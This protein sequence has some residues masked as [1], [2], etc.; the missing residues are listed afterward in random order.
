MRFRNLRMLTL[1]MLLLA[2]ICVGQTVPAAADDP[3]KV[4]AKKEFDEKVVQTLDQVVSDAGFLRLPQN[5]ALIFAMVGDLY[6]K[7]DEKRARDLFRSSGS[8]ILSYNADVER[9]KRDRSEPTVEFFDP[10][11]PRKIVL[12]LVAK[13]DAELGLEMLLQTRPSAVTEAMLKVSMPDFREWS[14]GYGYSPDY[15][16]VRQEIDLEQRFALLAADENPDRAIKMIKD[17]LAKGVSY[18]VLPLLQKLHKKD[19]KKAVELA[20]EVIRKLIDS[21]LIRKMDE[22]NVA[23]GFLQMMSRQNQTPQT[24]GD[25][26]VKEFRFTDV[27]AKDLA[28]KIVG[29]LTAPGTNSMTISSLI[30]RALPLIEKIAP[31]K[32]ALLKQKQSEN[33]KVMPAEFRNMDR[34]QKFWDPNTTPEQLIAELPKLQNDMER[35][36]AYQFLGRK[37]AEITDETRAKKLIDQIPDEKARARA[38]EQLDSEKI[39]R[40]AAAGKLE[41]ARKMIGTLT[42]KRVQIQKL[43]SL[44]EAFYRKGTE[45]DIESASSLMKS[46]R[47]LVIEPAE[48]EDEMN[49]LMEVV[50]GYAT[51]DPDSGFKMFEPVVDQLNEIV[52]ATAILSK[53]NKRSRTFKQGEMLIR[54]G[55]YSPDNM[56]LFR[57]LNHIQLLAKA[58]LGRM[59]SVTDRFQRSDVRT[60]VRLMAVQGALRDDKKP[61]PAMPPLAVGIQ[62]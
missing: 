12:P 28:N 52:Y 4:K 44:A 23:I 22:F 47:S 55:D 56:M 33:Q 26:K 9:D 31:E 7:Y 60:L 61:N 62:Y 1:T 58:D 35:N 30:T 11:D 6:W 40:A 27:Q 5:K 17:G 16:R 59:S 42:N 50:K 43:V 38:Q 18:S 24:N 21:D 15:Q 45:A 14:G 29:T 46:A 13:N 57:Y 32:V 34:M 41:E 3:E 54:F 2:S 49:N 25:P 10:N 51:V 37:I 20:G 48:D 8:E 53:Y 19:E 39:S 36:N